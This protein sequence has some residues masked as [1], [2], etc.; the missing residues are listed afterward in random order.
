MG[1]PG[2]VTLAQRMHARLRELEAGGRSITVTPAMEAILLN[3]P[4]YVPRRQDVRPD[5]KPTVREVD[6]A[7]R[8]LRTTIG[9]LVSEQPHPLVYGGPPSAAEEEYRRVHREGGGSATPFT[10]LLFPPKDDHRA[11]ALVAELPL[12]QAQGDTEEEALEALREALEV[13]LIHGYET[14]IAAL[15]ASG[16]TFV[17]APFAFQRPAAGRVG[18]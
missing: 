9:A 13:L 6:A 4:A 7:A 15:D 11:I 12:L 10:A 3:D 5:R 17:K 8:A 2:T 14:T 16:R 1:P 18:S